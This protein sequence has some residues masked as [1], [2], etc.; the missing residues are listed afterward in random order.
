MPTPT[1]QMIPE[2]RKSTIGYAI[3]YRALLVSFASKTQK[4]LA[5]ST[6]QA[7]IIALYRAARELEWLS[8]VTPPSPNKQFRPHLVFTDNSSATLKLQAPTFYELSKHL[9][10]R[11]K[12]LK[13]LLEANFGFPQ[14]ENCRHLYCSFSRTG[15][16]ARK[17]VNGWGT[18]RVASRNRSSQRARTT[19]PPNSA[20]RLVAP[21]AL[22]NIYKTA[23][24]E[25]RRQTPRKD[26]IAWYRETRGLWLPSRRKGGVL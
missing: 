3:L 1:L 17:T 15:A 7:K 16:R 24:S 20:S 21:I 26:R 18:T 8:S 5:H 14:Q 10:L 22:L 25:N 4:L 19:S 11:L 13:G 2:T 9:D 23:S 6:F 12:Y